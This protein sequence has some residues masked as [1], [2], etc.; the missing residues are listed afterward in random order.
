MR[1]C[2]PVCH[3]DKQMCVQL[4][5]SADNVTLLAFAAVCRAAAP[6]AATSLRSIDRL[7]PARRA[8]NSKPAA[9]ACSG[10]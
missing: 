10:Q 4:P 3:K 2:P 7:S 6:A 5:A 9:A 8:E 1:V